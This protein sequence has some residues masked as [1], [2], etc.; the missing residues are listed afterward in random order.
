[1][2]IGP[3]QLVVLGFPDPDFHGAIITELD[4]LRETDTIRVID[5]LAVHKDFGG[6]IEVAHLSNISDEEAIELGSKIGALIGLGI[7]GEEGMA[8]GAAVGADAA[9]DGIEMFSDEDAWDVLS[10]VPD[11]SAAALLLLEH[12]WAIPLRD[13]VAATGGFRL[14]DGFVSPLD[15]ITIGLVSAEEAKQLHALETATPSHT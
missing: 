8:A 13:A 9:A 5:A 11:G 1:M 4:R 10:E 15:L 2:T 12:R 7:E 6:G 3:V 14:S